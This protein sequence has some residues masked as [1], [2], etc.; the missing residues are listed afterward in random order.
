MPYRHNEEW[1]MRII[2][3]LAWQEIQPVEKTTSEGEQ[4][5]SF[6]HHLDGEGLIQ[7]SSAPLNEGKTRTY[8]LVKYGRLKGVFDL[9]ADGTDELVYDRISHNGKMSQHEA[10]VDCSRMISRLE[11]TLTDEDEKAFY[12]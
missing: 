10:E 11:F 3:S 12:L 5:S 6:V 7:V 1:R 4:F 9:R 8:R 2:L